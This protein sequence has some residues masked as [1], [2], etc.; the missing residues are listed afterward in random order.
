MVGSLF[1]QDV[2][3]SGMSEM[4]KQMLYKAN[5]KSPMFAGFLALISPTSGHLYINGYGSGQLRGYKPYLLSFSSLLMLSSAFYFSNYKVNGEWVMIG[6]DYA[7]DILFPTSIPLLF[8][9]YILQFQDATYMAKQ[10]NV[11]LY[12]KIYGKKSIIQPKKS[13]VQKMIDKKEAKKTNP[14]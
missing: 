10:H 4:E 13:L 5:D 2:D 8:S 7:E 14:L 3:A 6:D 11:E 12:E 9:W 1:A